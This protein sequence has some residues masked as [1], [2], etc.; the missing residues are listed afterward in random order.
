MSHYI[1]TLNDAQRAAVVNFNAPSLIVAGAGS[2][3]TRVLTCRIAYMLEQ[4]V[5][6]RNILALT[7][8]NKAA[9]EMR[10]RI[11]TL[12]SSQ[13]SRSLWMG[14]FHSIFA[15]ILRAEAE[16][17][18]YP[19]SFTIYDTA[20]SKNVIKGIVKE[21]NLSDETY[22]IG[23]LASRISLAKNN[24]VVPEAYEA[25]ASYI[26]ED[27][28][29]RRPQFAEV[30]KQYVR[31]CKEFGAM[32]FDDLLLNINILFRDH[33]EA[34]AKY[35][36]RFRYILVD[37]YQ[38]TNYAQY[39]IIRRLAQHHA[40]V[41]VVGDDAQS[42]YSFRGAKIENILRF[43]NDF[44][45][46]Q[47]FKLE[48]NY[49]STQTIVNAAN[50]VIEKNKKQIRKASFSREDKGEPIKVLRAYTDQE[51][52]AIIA[53][54]MWA[55]V[56]DTHTEYSEFAILYRT[57]AQSRVLEEALRKRNIPYKIYGGM[58]FYQRKEIKDLVAYIR[59]V[60]NP[61][62]DE[63]FR[64]IINYPARG[65]G[66]VT[67]G[68]IA[69]AAARAGLSLWDAVSTLDPGEMDLR[70]SAG[71]K[72]ADFT[73]M[74][75][76]LGE[77]KDTADAYRLGLEIA[78][79][80]GIL[81]SFKI[82]QTPEAMSAVDNIEELL[83]SIQSF[84]EENAERDPEAGPVT[85][86]EWLQN[87]ALLTD[88]DNE[89]PEERNKVI[90]MTVHAAKGLEYKYV[91]IAGLE[92]NLFPSLMSM[93]GEEGLEEE[94][95]LFYV[96]LTRAKTAAVLSF[97]QQR[98]K[99][100]EMTFSQPSRFLK[101]IDPQYLDVAFELGGDEGGEESSLGGSGRREGRMPYGG[102][103]RYEGGA[104]P[105][106]A[107][108]P[109]YGRRDGEDRHYNGR[110]I[111]RKREEGTGASGY[112]AGSPYARR[113][114]AAGQVRPETVPQVGLGTRFKSVGRRPAESREEH[115]SV[116]QGVP[117]AAVG[118]GS[119]AAGG[120]K[121]VDSG[122]ELVV[123]ALVEHDKFGRGRVA[124]LETMAGDQK[125]T[126]EFEA[127]GRRTLLRKFAKLRVIG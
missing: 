28:E 77:M 75:R 43:K 97:A 66:D 45:T 103:G 122:G 79:R 86:E 30:Y 34:L 74:I 63:A 88:A 27:R 13:L 127:A 11:G 115:E 111:Y 73:A 29:R 36:E 78:T 110:P 50:S 90:L 106:G 113:E 114:P 102:Q 116:R 93:N 67:V 31:K 42:I 126:V 92:E 123:G 119:G 70:G 125:I 24:L 46:A 54:D 25:N 8:T 20:D 16:L 109:A 18:G 17:L 62:D 101:E 85:I 112:G 69:D 91:Y 89:K 51:E 71:K 83:N 12:V 58:S 94:R 76:S 104:T 4:G 65:I 49:R 7:F 3:K 107:G 87:I 2:G 61:R 14:T 37:E 52:A 23:D 53:S 33:P 48:Q 32:D 21:M 124:A 108:R 84:A 64:R 38:D 118:S 55:K 80:S 44:P 15:R 95:R 82:Q 57:N 56:M 120:V 81:G 5:A 6:P 19:S 10:E 9:R 22:K 96:A 105:A 72:V 1:E 60:V 47:V 59:L 100:G 35:Q 98:F 39:I 41:C 26:A 99:W 68:R 40:N 117:A 121:A